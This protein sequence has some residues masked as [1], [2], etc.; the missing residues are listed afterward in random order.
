MGPPR[1][2]QELSKC[3]DI[4][5]IGGKA[6]SLG[7]LVR[8]G[9]PVPD[10]FVVTTRAWQPAA[11]QRRRCQPCLDGR[12]VHL[13]WQLARRVA[14]HLGC[15]QD[16]EWAIHEGK[17]YL[18][19]SRPITTM[20]GAAAYDRVLRTTQRRLRQEAAARRGPWVRHNLAETL[21]HP[22]PLTWS[23]MKRFMS[24]SGGFGATYRQ[25]GFEPAP[26]V[27]SDGFLL[28]IAGRIYMDVTR[29][30][31]MLF[32][33]F[34]FAYDL[35]EL[36]RNLDTSQL[37]PT[38]P[39]GSSLSRWKMGRKL[40][41][42]QARL[43]ALSADREH[44]LREDLFKEI[45]AFAAGAKLMDLGSLPV[46]GL[47]ELWEKQER[48]VL[49]TFG[50][51]LL[52]PGPIVAMALGAL[53]TF[54]QE[55]L[56]DED[57]DALAQFLSAGGLPDRTLTA[58]AELCEVAK[59]NR[60]LETWLADHGHR[61]AGELDLAEPRWRERPAA[62]RERADRLGTGDGPLERHRRHV[63]EIDRQAAAL[64]TRLTG[65][66]RREFDKHLC[67]VRCYVIL[68]EDS[69]DFLMFGYDLLRDLALEAGRRMDI[70][71]DVFYLTR[72]EVFDSLRV[73]FAP[74]HLIEQR[75]I[76]YR[77]ESRLAL[78]RVIDARAIDT[79]GQIPTVE[80]SAGGH[81]AL[82]VSS[83][84]STGTAR[85]VHSP[86]QAGDLGQRYILVCASTD[87]SW[88]PLFVNAAGLVLECGGTLS[89]GAI[90]A[91]EMGLPAVV[92]PGAT[93]IFHE[94]EEIRIDGRRGWVGPA[95][96][97]Q[98]EQS[99]PHEGTTFTVRLPLPSAG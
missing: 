19:Q 44:E 85:I 53:R 14:R 56:W 40:T 30:P 89:H 87:P 37:Q 25:A 51:R 26:V 16:I 82:V 54:L 28:S 31:E 24:G 65:A 94:G 69:K 71:D 84:E 55:T 78:P 13:L 22:T 27:E 57:A 46:D 96:V 76:A 91:R 75:K 38:Q 50:P 97:V 3:R 8:A 70:G 35:E 92:L 49:D 17:L 64:R 93:R 98:N 95:G 23:I 29:A 42:V 34:P 99:E 41:A 86:T 18:L 20:A 62:A 9:F 73:G 6:A 81:K 52:L 21:P 33:D 77:T 67:L 2:I 60:S 12:D 43:E 79:L 66:Q 88:T 59:G 68:R 10:G 61:A 1:F 48:K 80:P 11:E 39:F 15:P 32:P 4:L 58:D 36:K 45:V 74:C 83:G 47:L 7:R 63:K 5:L 90:V 72:D